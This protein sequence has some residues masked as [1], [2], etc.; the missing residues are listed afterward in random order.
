M[1]SI[2]LIVCQVIGIGGKHSSPRKPVF[3]EKTV[4]LNFRKSTYCAL[5]DQFVSFDNMKALVEHLPF[6]RTEKERYEG[7]MTKGYTY[8]IGGAIGG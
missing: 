2:L 6:L 1:D 8:W 4:F 3:P 7:V 5:I